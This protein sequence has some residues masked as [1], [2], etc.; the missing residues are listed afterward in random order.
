MQT[1]FP[2]KCD[3]HMNPGFWKD[4]VKEF[5]I[6]IYYYKYV[7]A[8]IGGT[9]TSVSDWFHSKWASSAGNVIWTKKKK[10]SFSFLFFMKIECDFFFNKWNSQPLIHNSNSSE[11]WQ[12]KHRVL[13][14]N[15]TSKQKSLFPITDFETLL[16]ITGAWFEPVWTFDQRLLCIIL[17]NEKETTKIQKN[18]QTKKTTTSLLLHYCYC[19]FLENELTDGIFQVKQSDD[20]IL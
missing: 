6:T 8:S 17:I 16:I 19:Y 20:P 15:L 14:L 9:S 4:K 3:K 13:S 12:A 1:S 5:N 11:D 2:D 7:P 18:K 10:K